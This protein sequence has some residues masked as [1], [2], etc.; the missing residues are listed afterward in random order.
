MVREET[1]KKAN[2]F[3]T[4]L[5]GQKIG[6]ICRKRRNEKRSKSGLSKNRSLTMLENCAGMYFI[7]PAG[8]EFKDI[9]KN[10]RR[11]LD[12]PVPAAMPCR[13]RREESR[14]TC[15]VS[16]NGKTTYA[17]IVEA[18]ENYE[19]AYGRNSDHIAWRGI[20][21]LNHYNLVHKFI[22]TP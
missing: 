6:K 22:P 18:D 17:C 21:S 4:R 16:E 9:L 20:D 11:K 3:Q 15:S 7:D 12:V 1:D 2:D 14:K 10:A 13:T 5:C 19:K 8:E